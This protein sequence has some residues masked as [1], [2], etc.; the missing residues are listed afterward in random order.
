MRVLSVLLGQGYVVI[1]GSGTQRHVH[2]E[3]DILFYF[4]NRPSVGY[5]VESSSGGTLVRICTPCHCLT[6][7]P[8]AAFTRRCCFNILSPLKAG[9]VM[10]IAYMLPQPPDISCTRRDVGWSFEARI[11]AIDASASVMSDA[12]YASCSFRCSLEEDGVEK[13]LADDEENWRGVVEER[14]LMR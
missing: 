7:S 11:A 5:F 8:S 9:E 14:K 12:A 3:L 13:S 10:S 1:G 2:F 6:R 4:S